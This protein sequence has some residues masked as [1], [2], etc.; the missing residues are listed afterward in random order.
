MTPRPWL[1]ARGSGPAA[2]EWGGEM[3]RGRGKGEGNH[4]GALSQAEG[5]GEMGREGAVAL[6]EGA[7]EGC[8]AGNWTTS[9]NGFHSRVGG[10]GWPPLGLVGRGR[11]KRA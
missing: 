10:R 9:T 3:G 2:G 11:Q 1:L 7:G 8:R 6:L 4:C 5:G